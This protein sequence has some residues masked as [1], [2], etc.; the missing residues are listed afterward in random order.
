MNGIILLDKPAGFTSFDAVA[1]MRGILHTK[2]IGHAGTLDPNATGLLLILVGHATKL[3]DIL[4]E[5]DKTYRASM[6]FGLMT[7]TEDIWGTVQTEKEVKAS[8]VEIR[9]AIASFEGTYDQ[10][11]PMYSAKKVNGEKLYDLARKG[12]VIERKPVPITIH[13]V[14]DVNITLPDAEMTV[15]CSKGTYIRTLI[16]D[17]AERAGELA[18]MTG[19]RRL[20]HGPFSLEN[21]H[22]FS[23][24]EEAVKNGTVEELLISVSAVYEKCPRVTVK[25]EYASRALNGNKLS[26]EM[27]SDVPKNA[28]RIRLY[29]PDGRFFALYDYVSE[30]WKPFKIFN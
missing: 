11:P 25:E 13:S 22:T 10:V 28:E 21:A 4:P 24:V 1:K 7:D 8:E 14:T 19:L 18:V 9:D 27:L 30:E 12:I 23:E 16:K 3:S 5:N 6:R 15:H 2:K 17:M 29:L 26:P 20:S